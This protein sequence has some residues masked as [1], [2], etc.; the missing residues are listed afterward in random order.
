M[1]ALFH[2]YALTWLIQQG[3]AGEGFEK[4]AQ[5]EDGQT[6]SKALAPSQLW[7]ESLWAT[8]TPSAAEAL[9]HEKNHE[10]R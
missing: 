6:P 4:Q 7:V 8:S 1:N 5:R 10:N 3:R 2:H 9:A